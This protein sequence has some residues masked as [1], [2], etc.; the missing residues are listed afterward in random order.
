[1]S[2]YFSFGDS[3]DTE[4]NLYEECIRLFQ[5]AL[6]ENNECVQEVML[7]NF[8]ESSPLYNL[9]VEFVKKTTPSLSL[10]LQKVNSIIQCLTKNGLDINM[11]GYVWEE[12]NVAPVHYYKSIFN[13]FLRFNE[14]SS[15]QEIQRGR[16]FL[17]LVMLTNP[18]LAK[19][20]IIRNSDP[21]EN[22]NPILFLIFKKVIK[23]Q[24]QLFDDLFDD[25]SR[26]MF[27]R[28]PLF[29]TFD[30]K[31]L[32]FLNR[33][34]Q[35]QGLDLEL[36]NSNGQNLLEMVQEFK[37]RTM[38]M[39]ENPFLDKVIDLVR[40]A[41]SRKT[42]SVSDYNVGYRLTTIPEIPEMWQESRP[43]VRR[44]RIPEIRQ[45]PPR[46]SISSPFSSSPFSSS[47]SSS[48]FTLPIIGEKRRVRGFTPGD[49]ETLG[50]FENDEFENDE[51][52]KRDNKNSFLEKFFAFFF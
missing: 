43:A 47:S 12:G 44:V 40:E 20:K 19:N 17:L 8:R 36:M 4:E 42:S 21:Q 1:M 50:E 41:L 24:I 29:D 39:R 13:C 23:F 3:D 35:V 6:L 52:R 18:L 30:K 48:S 2:S 37:I 22:G 16:E 14:E 28:D 25:E 11:D 9:Y 38:S 49:D 51:K 34:C 27:T 33:L 5:C 46:S 15:L 45:R 10:T 32:D 7:K 31:S 26:E